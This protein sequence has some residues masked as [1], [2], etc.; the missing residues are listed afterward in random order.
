MNHQQNRM[1]GEEIRNKFRIFAHLTD[2]KIK[3]INS[4]FF[5]KNIKFKRH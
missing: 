4:G 1:N 2:E 3:T 5:E